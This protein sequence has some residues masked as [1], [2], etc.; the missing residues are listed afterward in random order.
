MTDVSVR[1]HLFML[2]TQKEGRSLSL[3]LNIDASNIIISIF[4]ACMSKEEI[5]PQLVVLGIDVSLMHSFG[6]FCK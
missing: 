6:I 2:H 5:F 3:C 1:L 4:A